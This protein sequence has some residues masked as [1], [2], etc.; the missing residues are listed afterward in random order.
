[1]SDLRDQLAG[2]ATTRQPVLQPPFEDIE[3]RSRERRRRGEVA[4][5]VVV[6]AVLVGA[7]A[8]GVPHLRGESETT[9]ASTLSQ[10]EYK[11]PTDG[12][13]EGQGGMDALLQGPFHAVVRD[14][15]ACAWLGDREVQTLW[16][17]GYRLRTNPLE[18]VD[19]R[20]RVV[21]KEGDHLTSGGGIVPGDIVA[22][23][24]MAGQE[25]VHLQGLNFV[26]STDDPTPMPPASRDQLS[27]ARDA[28]KTG[29]QEDPAFG[30]SNI[31]I[32]SYTVQ[33]FLTDISSG[34]LDR[35]FGDADRSR[36]RVIKVAR[37]LADIAVLRDKVSAHR[38]ELQ[39]QGVQL[40]SW[41]ANILTNKLG[42]GLDPYT[43][44]AA[45]IIRALVG[46]DNVEVTYSPRGHAW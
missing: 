43:E 14:G 28:I 5:G 7:A 30:G 37:S 8:L 46:A 35:I 27:A 24:R 20:G 9:P 22:Q 13:T 3:R 16:P 21:A 29:F 42:V 4:G 15:Q 10:Q 32:T 38:D 11:L 25:V 31:D 19:P 17:K 44:E 36:F 34:T 39:S 6:A 12:W 40:S 23:C 2:V 1:M 41:G 18:L 26:R 33:F 45:D